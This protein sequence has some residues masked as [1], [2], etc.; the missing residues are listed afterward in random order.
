M[1][2]YILKRILM[3]VPVMLGIL[4]MVFM[5]MRVFA[6]NPAWL[7]LGQEATGEKVA[8][9][10]AHLGLDQPLIVQYGKFLS[11]CLKGDFGTSLFTKQPVI[12]ELMQRLP[13][14]VEL[15]LVS[16]LISSILGVLL[17]VVSAVRQYSVLDYA[18]QVGGLV[19]VSMPI[20]WTGLM[21][22]IAFSVNLGWLPVSGR[23]AFDAK[24][25]TITGLMLLD[26]LLTGNLMAFKK[27]FSYIVLPAISLGIQST[28]TIMRYTRS[29]MLETIRQ[30]YIRTARAKGLHE[31]LVIN[32]HALKNALIPIVT[33]IGMQLGGLLGGAV[34]TETIFAWPGVGT[35]I[36]NGI[37]NSDYAVVQGGCVLV[38]LISVLM[39]LVVD[40]LY[41]YLDPRIRYS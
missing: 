17:G 23:F 33:V 28:A 6:P 41:A 19:G 8:E 24:P 13:A 22:I 40:V 21:L 9:L 20:F 30:D 39:N 2:K 31:R 3:A 4:T 14:T 26:S 32:R 15:A 27:C 38:A 10:T 29:A 34:L 36:V 11:Q 12:T 25:E 5:L 35:Y 7:L 1:F 37:N 18:C 16:V